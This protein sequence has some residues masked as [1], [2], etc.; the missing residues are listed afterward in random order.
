MKALLFMILFLLTIGAQ[1]SVVAT[2]KKAKAWSPSESGEGSFQSLDLKISI[3]KNKI[4]KLSATGVYKGVAFDIPKVQAEE[5][6][7]N[8]FDSIVESATVVGLDLTKA[9]NASVY[10]LSQKRT[11][12]LTVVKGPTGKVLG[13]IFVIEGQLGTCD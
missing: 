4:G 9:K 8:Q 12:T 5:V 6:L 11:N 1:A 3:N 2:C 7:N 10:F 13:K